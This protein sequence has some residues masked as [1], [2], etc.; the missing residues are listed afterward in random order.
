ME[1]LY[2]KD[3]NE[4]KYFYLFTYL[5]GR[6][7]G[8]KRSVGVYLLCYV[9]HSSVGRA[10]HEVIIYD[11]IFDCRYGGTLEC[12]HPDPYNSK[13][14]TMSIPTFFDRIYDCSYCGIVELYPYNSDGEFDAEE[15]ID[16]D[17]PMYNS[18]QMIHNYRVKEKYL[19]K[20]YPMFQQTL[21]EIRNGAYKWQ[22]H[23]ET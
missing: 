11:M 20:V 3:L 23:S 21:K 8:I 15:I 22:E 5:H 17:I 6:L 14:Y 9:N 18:D 12:Y 19:R 1:Q 16:N 13:L 2:I 10:K 7:T 4:G